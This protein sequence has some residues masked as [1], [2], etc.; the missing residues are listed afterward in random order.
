MLGRCT[1]H[2][3]V[4]R[5]C[6]PGAAAAGV[7]DPRAARGRNGRGTDRPGHDDPGGRCGRRVSRLA[8]ISRH[9]RHGAVPGSAAARG[10][11]LWTATVA[12]EPVKPRRSSRRQS[13]GSFAFRSSRRRRGKATIPCSSSTAGGCR[14]RACSDRFAFRCLRTENINVELSQVYLHVPER[15]NGS[16]CG[17]L[18]QDRTPGELEKGFQTYLNKRIQDAPAGVGIQRR[19]H[20]GA[21]SGTTSSRPASCWRTTAGRSLGTTSSNSHW[22]CTTT[23]MSN[24]SKPATRPS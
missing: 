14:L 9:Q 19:L 24:N 4:R 22:R 5:R 13:R 17:T 8:G 10:A 21:R 23:T 20:Q 6:R 11:R 18:R 12:G 15:A 1:H 7:F 2:A 3:G 16:I